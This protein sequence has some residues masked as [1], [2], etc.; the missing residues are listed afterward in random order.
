M[1]AGLDYFSAG[2][3]ARFDGK[4]IDKA[5]WVYLR[6]TQPESIVPHYFYWDSEESCQK[7]I[8]TDGNIYRWNPSETQIAGLDYF[9]RVE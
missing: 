4:Q 9:I 2:Y 6:E 7:I 8:Y 5:E 3:T 1:N